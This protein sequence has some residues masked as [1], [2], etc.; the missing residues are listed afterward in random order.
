MVGLEQGADDHVVKPLSPREVTLRA[1]R[2]LRM[3]SS[4]A[5]TAVLSMTI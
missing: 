4:R 5:P 1:Q 2:L 3:S